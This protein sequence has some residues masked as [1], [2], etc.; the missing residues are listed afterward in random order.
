MSAFAT[1]LPMPRRGD[2]SELG[3]NVRRLRTQK[4]LTQR[5]LAQQVG[6]HRVTITRIENGQEG[7]DLDTLERMVEVFG[8][9]Y[10]DLVGP[11]GYAPLNKAIRDLQRDRKMMAE[12]GEITEDE[13]KLLSAVPEGYWILHP[14]DKDA[15]RRMLLAM[16]AGAP[17]R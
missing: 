17:R 11:S 5:E 8:C 2:P 6:V 3:Q 14:P 16:R 10:E 4:G 15:L 9:K 7:A 1:Y 13:R 12:I